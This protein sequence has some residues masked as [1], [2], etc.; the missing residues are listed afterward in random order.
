MGLINTL[1]TFQ[2]IINYILYDLL[3]NKVWVYIDN[4][5][6]YAE[7]IEEYDRLVLDI[8]KC[9]RRNNLTIAP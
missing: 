6:I 8:L 7:T 9:L 5:F 1:T 2:A 3:D 4:I